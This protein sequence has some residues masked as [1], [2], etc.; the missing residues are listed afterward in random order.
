MGGL[1]TTKAEQSQAV[2]TG[3]ASFAV[4][5]GAFLHHGV[6]TASAGICIFAGLEIDSV[7][8]MQVSL[9]R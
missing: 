3:G 6:L 7:Q 5:V 1:D 2:A 8:E 4:A 9:R